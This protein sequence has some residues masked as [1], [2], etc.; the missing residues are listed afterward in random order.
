MSRA[1][2]RVSRSVRF[3]ILL[4]ARI[5]KSRI[6]GVGRVGI[7]FMERVCLSGLRLV[8][9]QSVRFVGE[10]LIMVE[11]FWGGMDVRWFG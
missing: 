8:G 10:G 11:F 5:E 9:G 6:S 2:S 1:R 4:L 7:C 3:A